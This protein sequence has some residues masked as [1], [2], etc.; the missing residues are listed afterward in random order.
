MSEPF[1]GKNVVVGKN[2]RFGEDVVIWNFVVIGENTIIG[3]KTRVGSF[4][5]IGK[6]VKIGNSCLVQTHVTI[7]NG[8]RIGDNVFVA[9]NVSFLNDKFPVT[10]PLSP[11][12][13]E[14]DVIIGGCAIVLPNVRIRKE[15]I[16]GA[17]SLVTKNV[18]AGVLVMG[19]PARQV[20][21]REEYEIKREEYKRALSR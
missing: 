21:A 18:P 3:D 20:M 4:C 17:G 12:I 16:V 9:P 10:E 7:S 5:D 1:L 2:V 13:I 6:N 19:S 8:C 11:P 15:S 14:D